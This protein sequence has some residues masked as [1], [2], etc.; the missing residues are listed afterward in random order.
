M[1]RLGAL[2]CAARLIFSADIAV[3]A[4][5]VWPGVK[6]ALSE[7]AVLALAEKCG[8]LNPELVVAIVHVESAGY[9]AVV[10]DGGRAWGLM[11]I[12]LT[13][14]RSI[15][16]RGKAKGLLVPGV[17]MRWG[18]KYL[19]LKGDTYETVAAQAAAYNAGRAYICERPK[20][21]RSGTGRRKYHAKRGQFVNQ[22][23]VDKVMNIY[24]RL[25]KATESKNEEPTIAKS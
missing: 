13:T 18:I 25:L 3:A 4:R 17:G 23:Y 7:E 11:Q 5:D 12:H 22:H 6:P 20:G 14:A 15:G 24:H 21:C 10:G 8:A 1:R 2:I 19:D 9:P 16:Y